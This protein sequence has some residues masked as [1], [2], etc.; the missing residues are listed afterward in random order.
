MSNGKGST[1][2]VLAAICSLIVPGLGQLVQGRVLWALA[3]FVMAGVAYAITF[4]LSIGLLPVG[5]MLVQL[6]SCIDA[7]V[8]KPKG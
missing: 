7:A 5:G 3:W 6:L 4:V 2:N 8:Y 1:G